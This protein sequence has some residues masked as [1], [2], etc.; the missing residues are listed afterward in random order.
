M[1]ATGE[2]AAAAGEP[3]LAGREETEEG[4][5]LDAFSCDAAEADAAAD[6]S[7]E[8]LLLGE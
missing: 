4:A 5:V 1:Q 7:L 2:A 6:A 8:D 3:D